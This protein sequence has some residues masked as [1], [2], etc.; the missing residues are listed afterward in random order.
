MAYIDPF[1]LPANYLVRGYNSRL[2]GNAATTLPCGMIV[3]RTSPGNYTV[4]FG[5]DVRNRFISVTISNAGLAATAYAIGDG[6][7][8]SVV[9]S[10]YFAVTEEFLDSQFFIF[11]F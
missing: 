8:N 3:T 4:D 2:A 7:P 6:A 11:V 5:F 10:T 1:R 9:V